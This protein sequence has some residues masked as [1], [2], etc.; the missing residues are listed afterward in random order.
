[1]SANRGG[2]GL[3]GVAGG[4]VRRDVT[5]RRRIGI[6][7]EAYLAPTLFDERRQP[8]GK[9]SL[10]QGGSLLSERPR[11]YEPPPSAP[12]PP[13]PFTFFFRPEPAEKRGTLPPGMKM[14]S[15]VRG[16]TP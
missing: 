15:P 14:R 9:W 3:R 12:P 2:R 5:E 8:V 4:R 16:L 13:E 7:P 1:M 10:G 11:L 6:E